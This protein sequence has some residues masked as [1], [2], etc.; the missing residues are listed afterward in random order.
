MV[1]V[2]VDAWTC[3]AD[4]DVVA[5]GDRESGMEREAF[6][7]PTNKLGAWDSCIAV[8]KTGFGTCSS[9]RIGD[10]ARESP[11]MDVVKGLAGLRESVG[12]SRRFL[13]PA[14]D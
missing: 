4:K 6:S 11:D 8:V 12:G 10:G 9:S 1:D 3:S 2:D 7:C 13:N 5:A 14:G